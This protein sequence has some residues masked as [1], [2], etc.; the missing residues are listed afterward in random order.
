MYKG[1]GKNPSSSALIHSEQSAVL[2]KA[3]VDIK[4]QTISFSS[5][6]KCVLVN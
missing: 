4:G 1:N 3:P 6:N 2:M 5:S